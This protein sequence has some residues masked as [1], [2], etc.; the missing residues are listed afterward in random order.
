MR[1]CKD[2]EAKLGFLAFE[3]EVLGCTVCNPLGSSIH[4]I[5]MWWCPAATLKGGSKNMCKE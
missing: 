5:V 1:S 3:V 2:V 4:V